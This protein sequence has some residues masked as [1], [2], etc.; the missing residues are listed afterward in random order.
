M[1]MAAC[2][3][4]W[5]PRAPEPR[6]LIAVAHGVSGSLLRSAYLGLSREETLAQD[7]PQDAIFLLAGRRRPTALLR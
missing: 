3:R 7:M 2:A 5:P 1:S 4:G 6:K